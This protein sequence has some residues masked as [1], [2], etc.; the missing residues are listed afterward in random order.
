VTDVIAR[1]SVLAVRLPPVV[2]RRLAAGDAGDPQ[3]VE[4]VTEAP[5]FGE[6]YAQI[7]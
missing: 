1:L 3:P 6:D 7:D 2:F 5:A 4:G